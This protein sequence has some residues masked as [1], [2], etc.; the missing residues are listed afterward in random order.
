[1]M[2]STYGD[3]SRALRLISKYRK[4]VRKFEIPKAPSRKN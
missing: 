2:A 1:M 4:P 3:S